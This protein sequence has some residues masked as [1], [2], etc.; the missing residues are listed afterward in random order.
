MH[1]GR[2]ARPVSL[3]TPRE[4]PYLISNDADVAERLRLTSVSPGLQIPLQGF[5]MAVS[6][7]VFCGVCVC[8]CVCVCVVCEGRAIGAS[9]GLPGVPLLQ[10]AGRR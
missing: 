8:E 6:G 1:P 9:P 3:R 2:G 5:D 4:Q 7:C 10:P